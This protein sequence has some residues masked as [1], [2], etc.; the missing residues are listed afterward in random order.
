MNIEVITFG[1]GVAT[2]MLVAGAI[3]FY[4]SYLRAMIESFARFQAE[5]G[6]SGRE[7]TEEMDWFTFRAYIVAAIHHLAQSD[8]WALTYELTHCE[9][10]IMPE[11]KKELWDFYQRAAPHEAAAVGFLALKPDMEVLIVAA[12]MANN[13]FTS[14]G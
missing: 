11:S 1:L 9:Y 7:L 10:I 3:M 4:Y 2:S 8:Y 13:R 6:R 5:R 14:S 12:G